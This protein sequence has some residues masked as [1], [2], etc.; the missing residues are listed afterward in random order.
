MKGNGHFIFPILILLSYVRNATDN[1][2]TWFFR[3][4]NGKTLWVSGLCKILAIKN[5]ATKVNLASHKCGGVLQRPVVLAYFCNFLFLYA[6]C[7]LV[8]SCEQF[9]G[10]GMVGHLGMDVLQENQLKNTKIQLF[11]I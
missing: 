9:H 3:I 7:F 5:W 2:F 6:E 10:P 8:G 4:D 11:M 1:N